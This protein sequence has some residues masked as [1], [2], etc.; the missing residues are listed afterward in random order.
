MG[1]SDCGLRIAGCGCGRRGFASRALLVVAAVAVVA[2]ALLPRARVRRHPDRI[3]VRFWHMWTGEWKDVVD[4]IVARYN[5]SQDKYE[6]IAL[7]VPPTG[8]DSKF[9]LGVVGGDPPDVM[10]QWNAVIPTWAENR[11]L[12]PLDELMTPEERA[13]FDREAYPIVKKLGSYKGHL[14][15]L[16]TGINIWACYYL[17]AHF[18]EAGLDPNHFPRTLEELQADADKMTRRDRTGS[19]IRLGFLPNMFLMYAPL[20]GGGFYDWDRNKLTIDTPANLRALTYLAEERRKLGYENVVRYEAGLNGANAQT[21]GIE[22]PFLT[23]AYSVTVDGQWRVEQIGKYAP[24]L[25]YR[26]APLPPPAGGKRFGGRSNGN[27]MIIPR[28]SKQVRGAWDFVKFW[29]GLS[30]PERAA[31]FYTWGGWLPLSPAIAEADAY[32]AYLRKYPQFRQFLVIL[33]SPNIEPLPPVPYQVYLSDR[34]TAAED[35]AVRGTLTPEAALKRL[36]AQVQ[37]ER[38]RRKELG[39]AE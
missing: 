24:N 39:Y 15:G 9:L 16:T 31:E 12:L 21:G 33:S 37:Q 19:L 38:A 29:S 2:V 23:G 13:R 34:I 36:D 35:A 32:Q 6:V 8:A 10:A 26:I 28:G 22:W 1:A 18:R 20:F 30:H 4:R 11:L 27:F 3:P 17:P 7:S 14:Y 25:D 5:A